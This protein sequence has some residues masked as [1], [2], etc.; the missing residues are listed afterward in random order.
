MQEAMVVLAS[1]RK[2][3]GVC[4]AGKRLGACKP[5][6]IRP[7]SGHPVDSWRARTLRARL[8]DIPAMG[9]CIE[10]PLQRPVPEGHQRENW[11]VGDGAWRRTGVFSESD[12]IELLDEEVPLWLNGFSSGQGLN[13]RI[14]LVL[15]TTLCHSSLKLIRPAK[16]RFSLAYSGKLKASFHWAGA[17]YHLCVTDDSVQAR[18]SH[19]LANGHDGH[20]DA[21]LT[22]SLGVP[23][24]GDCYKLVAGVTEIS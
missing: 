6:W 12:I 14:P 24:Q 16:L 2:S 20:C 3:G 8:G 22:I 4:L 23:F 15:A 7:V 9:E 11:L 13:D 1:S 10:L 18:W 19:L 5:E 21:A 17:A